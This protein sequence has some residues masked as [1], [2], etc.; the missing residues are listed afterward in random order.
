MNDRLPAKRI[1]FNGL[2]MGTGGGLT[3]G[4]ELAYALAEA[5]PDWHVDLFCIEGHPLHA[6]LRDD[7]RKPANV[8]LQWAPATTAGRV[9]RGKYEKNDLVAWADQNKIDAVFQLNGMIVKGMGPPSI[10]HFQDPWPYRSEAW[11]RKQ[12]AV[13]AWLKRRAHRAALRGAA[14][15]TWTS[16]YLD[17][18]ITSR[19]NL[20]P[21]RS[22]VLYNG[23]PDDWLDRTADQWV[24]MAERGR[25]L[26]T[27][28]N[29]S[30]YKRQW[31]VVEAVGKL[32]K[33]H[34]LDD[35]EYTIA[36]H[37]P[38]EVEADLSARIQRLGLEGKVHLAGRVT[39][40]RA[41]E[42]FASSRGYVL[43]SVCESFGIPAIE[44]MT[45]GTPVVVADCCAIPEVCGDAGWKVTTDDVEA[46]TKSLAEALT[47]D[48]AAAQAA[49]RGAVNA[50]R[51]RW[52][53]TAKQL[54]TL[55]EEVA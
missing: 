55:I 5:R 54:V 13:L 16:N 27:I 51:F 8:E 46:L 24:P 48:T 33:D 9:G 29:V 21:K 52:S 42:L 4:R 36:G 37:T 14:A 38:P 45:F 19:Q 47:D 17:G 50:R 3:V 20:Q 35:V 44:A 6:E 18:L 39:D 11:T 43:M 25:R 31:L 34:G 32:V 1:L 23:V 22:K 10:C 41:R 53:E 26:V 28:S 30:H 2:S 7:A 15:A 49:E 40:E 12:D